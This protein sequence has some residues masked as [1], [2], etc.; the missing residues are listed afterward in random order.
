MSYMVG[1]P[2]LEDSDFNPDNTLKSH[3]TQ[4]KPVVVMAQGTFCRF[5]TKAKP[6]FE[7]FAKSGEHNARAV[8]L[9]IDGGPSEKNAGQ[10]I[11]ALDKNYRGVPAYF[12]FNNT[13]K[14]VK[15]HNGGRDTQS[16]TDFAKTL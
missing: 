13:G 10:R 9:Q 1:V 6:D 8:T 16:I 15:T 4:G 11:S 14:Y 7:K 3:V 5:C 2:Y 12:G